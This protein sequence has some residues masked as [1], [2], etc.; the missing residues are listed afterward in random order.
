MLKEK[1]EKYLI[2]KQFGFAYYWLD[3]PL[4]LLCLLLLF[5]LEMTVVI[6]VL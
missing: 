2:G 5:F 6:L 3:F 4:F 1:W